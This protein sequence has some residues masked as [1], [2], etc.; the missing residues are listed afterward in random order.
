MELGA[1]AAQLGVAEDQLVGFTETMA[2]LGVSTNLSS[3]EAAQA[4]AEMQNIF[5]VAAGDMAED[6]SRVGSALVALGNNFATTERDIMNF[7][8]RIA[9]VGKI[10][11][12]TEADILGIGAAMASVGVEAEAG[13]TAVNTALLTIN[14]AVIAGNENL[15][16][17]AETAGMTAREFADR[18]ETDAAGAFTAFVEGLGA[19][20]DDAQFIM[21]ELGL[22]NARSI[23]AFLSLAGAGDLLARAIMTSNEAFAANLALQEEAERRYATT[24]AQW[25]ILK[26]TLRDILLVIGDK[27]LPI[28]N[29]FVSAGIEAAQAWGPKIEAALTPAIEAL[30]KFIDTLM[31]GE[32]GK[33]LLPALASALERLFMVGETAD[34][35]WLEGVAEAINF[36][37]SALADLIT[38]GNLRE[39]LTQLGIPPET[40]DSFLHFIDTVSQAITDLA[41]F[42]NNTLLPALTDVWAFIN[43]TLLPK[44]KDLWRW[45]AERLAEATQT[46]ADFWNNTLLPALTDVWAFINETLLPKLEDLWRWLAERLAEATRT[47]AD[48]WNNTLLPAL[49]DVWAFINE[50]LLPKL[51]ELAVK[52]AV[53]LAPAVADVVAALSGALLPALTIVG[54]FVEG[55]LLPLFVALSDFISAVLNVA[56]TAMAGIWQNV[57]RPALLAVGLVIASLLLPKL[58]DLWNLITTTIGPAVQNWV[59]G[60]LL[61]LQG[62]LN[63]I[64]GIIANVIRSLEILTFTLNNIRLPPWMT[65][66]SPTPWELGLRG[67]NEA[68]GELTRLGLP[69]FG[70]ALEQ[71]AAINQAMQDMTVGRTGQ[72][73]PGGAALGGGAVTNINYSYELNANY[74]KTQSPVRL[75]DDLVLMNALSGAG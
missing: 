17:F 48:S 74:A 18:W 4:I 68:L 67:V 49:T 43:E 75:M 28:V 32:F 53:D 62:A 20:G 8:S 55:S 41:D 61:A 64:A 72:I 46:L 39:F 1:L 37:S 70:S 65:P 2:A 7:A 69:R 58:T 33:K 26:N 16:V 3:E 27:L 59:N 6:A 56:V 34:F 38:T 52:M 63:T 22:D 50:T 15:A 9:G 23:R 42:W 30:S 54:G 31:E 21:D 66:G 36:I 57:L 25:Q 47:L 19:A 24:A 44:L 60:S 45:L 35:S 11:G 51:E 71:I 12:L 29:Q 5:D 73:L 13:G 40:V 10:A 14:E